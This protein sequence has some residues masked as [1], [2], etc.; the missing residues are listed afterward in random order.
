MDLEKKPGERWDRLENEP[1][2]AFEAFQIY[3]SLP[4]GGRTVVEA[5]RRHVD[6]PQA[7]KVSDT[8]ARWSNDFTWCL[9]AEAFDNYLAR[10]RREAF[11]QEIKETAKREVREAE[12]TRFRYSELLT[13]S[14]EESLLYIESGDF[15]SQMRPRD[16]VSVMRVFLEATTR[17]GESL[18]QENEIADW[19]EEEQR[20]FDKPLEEIEAGDQDRDSKKSEEGEESEDGQT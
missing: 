18:Q 7:T 11:E 4:S 14:Y 16:V 3:L 9:R 19:T 2:R 5:Y 13:R 12:T 10:L 20:E 1:R 6:N 17:F 15:L 8:W